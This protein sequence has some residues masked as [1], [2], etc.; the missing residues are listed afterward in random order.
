[1]RVQLHLAGTV[2]QN[3]VV[4]QLFQAFLEPLEI[5]FQLLEG[6]QDSA[7]RA[8][9]VAAHDLLQRDEIADV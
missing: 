1:M 8:K 9:V 3:I 2:K 6:V 5:V 4:T 7:V